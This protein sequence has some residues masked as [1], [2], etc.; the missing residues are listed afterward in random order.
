[1]ILNLDLKNAEHI[2]SFLLRRIR[3]GKVN[4]HENRLVPLKAIGIYTKP[5]FNLKEFQDSNEEKRRELLKN[6]SFIVEKNFKDPNIYVDIKNMI[7][8]GSF[9]PFAKYD[10]KELIAS[11]KKYLSISARCFDSEVILKSGISTDYNSYNTNSFYVNSLLK[12]NT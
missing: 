10:E 9:I 3:N 11:E 2:S 4:S 8:K 7:L 6:I 1:M 12:T 5:L